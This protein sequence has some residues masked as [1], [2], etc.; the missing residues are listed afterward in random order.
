M[1]Y[2]I[3]FEPNGGKWRIR[4][5]VF[6]LYF[7]PLSRVVQT[8]DPSPVVPVSTMQVKEFD[9]YAAAVKYVQE[10]GLDNAYRRV[11]RQGQYTTQLQGGLVHGSN[12]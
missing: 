9:T 1:V 8:V 3:Y 4:I 11:D 2:E 10:I 5:T 7:I 6:F 12:S